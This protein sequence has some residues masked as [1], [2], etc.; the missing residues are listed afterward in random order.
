[1]D[2]TG[3]KVKGRW[4][5]RCRAVDKEGGT[6]GF[7][8]RAHRGKVAARGDCEKAVG[9]NGELETITVNK[10]SANLGAVAKTLKERTQD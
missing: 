10:S 8:L 1:M 7:L 5:Y 2:E 4:K 3:I 9:Q 6:V